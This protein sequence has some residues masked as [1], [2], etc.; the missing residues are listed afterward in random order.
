MVEYSK[1]IFSL[2][3]MLHDRTQPDQNAEIAVFGRAV[4][5]VQQPYA[6]RTILP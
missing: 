1:N 6:L 2:K 4:L 5:L 3:E